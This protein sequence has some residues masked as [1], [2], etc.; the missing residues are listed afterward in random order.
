M[1][2]LTFQ[3]LS[4]SKGK[5]DWLY[6]QWFWEKNI[7][8]YQ[9]TA[10]AQRVCSKECQRRRS[11]YTQIN[12]KEKFAIGN[13]HEFMTTGYSRGPRKKS[14]HFFLF[15]C[16]FLESLQHAITNEITT[17]EKLTVK[18]YAHNVPKGIS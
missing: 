10:R 15:F 17:L 7:Q 11:I 6:L 12:D 1:N 9:L 5:I 18:I 8:K 16:W 14:Y 3:N 13:I 4:K 2:E